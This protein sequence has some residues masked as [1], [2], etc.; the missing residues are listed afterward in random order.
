MKF[1]AES[2][3]NQQIVN[4]VNGDLSTE[5]EFISNS[6]EQHTLDGNTTC[7]E[8]QTKLRVT[9]NDDGTII[10]NHDKIE[11]DGIQMVLVPA[12]T[13]DTIEL[14]KNVPTNGKFYLIQ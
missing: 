8:I 4:S 12:S 11:I 6:N 13:F 14:S 2:I 5:N 9:K 7:Y 3:P 1:T 10:Y